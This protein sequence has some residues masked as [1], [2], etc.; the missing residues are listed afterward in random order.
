MSSSEETRRV[1][2]GYFDAWTSK[3]VDDARA[4]LAEDL[5]FAG[6]SASYTSAKAFEPALAGFAAM[7]KWARVIELVATGDRAALLYD[8]ELPGGQVRI[9]SF[10]RVEAGK[11]R[12]Y[13][14]R[15]DPSVL[16]KP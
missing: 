2:Q 11:I 1:V 9:A 15:F 6:P 8:C 5:E 3:R 13:D 10:F 14:T 16:R 7:T 12:W 4:L